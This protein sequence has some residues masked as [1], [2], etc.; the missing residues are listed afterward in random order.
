MDEPSEAD[1]QARPIPCPECNSTKGYSRMGKYRS[2]CN[3]CNALLTNS[4]VGRDDQE[5]Q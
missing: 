1:R 4:E 2:Q 3:E 5:P